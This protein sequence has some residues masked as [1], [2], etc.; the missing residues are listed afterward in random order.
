M[1]R[2]PEPDPGAAASG[3]SPPVPDPTGASA[4]RGVAGLWRRHGRVL[5]ALGIGY[6]F[7]AATGRLYYALPYLLR[8]I[9]PWSA[10]DLK[11]RHNEVAQWFAGNPVY[12]VVDGAVY[13]PASH[14]ILWPFI[15]W[16]PLDTARLIWAVT[17]VAAAAV[18]GLLA[19]RACAPAPPRYRLLV[20]G[21]A[22]AGYPLQ[23]S[24]FPGQMGMHVVALVAGGAVLLLR[25][26]PA[27]WTDALAALM[28]AASLVK[29]TTALPLVAAALIAARRVRPAVLVVGGYAA[30]TLIAVAAQ[31]AGLLALLRD[32]LAVAGDRVPV[33]DGVPN[34]HLLLAWLGLRSW[35][36]AASLLVLAVMSIWGWRR[37][38]ADP[39]ILLG[40]AAVVARFWAHSTLYDDAFLLLAAVALF[41]VAF[42]TAAGTRRTAAW[43]LAAA[44][45]ALLTPTWVFYGLGPAIVQPVHAAQALLWLVALAVLVVVAHGQTTA[46]IDVPPDAIA[47]PQPQRPGPEDRLTP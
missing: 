38:D 23:L 30:F 17:T 14:A 4:Q 13:P 7:V 21:L 22:F 24:I 29:P 37:R 3:A 33:M 45:A 11:Y 39:W 44:W 27:W 18:I 35:M 19:Y 16:V 6:L 20:A 5:S 31:P 34:L 9:A 47:R 42:L 2:P 15:G 12:G 8:D 40:V 46:Y 28:I 36:N 26:R 41:R 32:W 1:H 10:V 25:E 43:L